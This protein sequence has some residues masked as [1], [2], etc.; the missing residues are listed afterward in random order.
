MY[1]KCRSRRELLEFISGYRDI[2]KLKRLSHR[3]LHG[4]RLEII[5][6]HENDAGYDWLNEDAD[7][8]PDMGFRNNDDVT[9]V[10]E[11]M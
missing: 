6:R 5:R 10:W 8:L 9:N 3:E 1:R 4:I 7:K 2:S 11:N